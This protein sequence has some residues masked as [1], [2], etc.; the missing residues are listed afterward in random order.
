MKHNFNYWAL[1]EVQT[2]PLSKRWLLFVCY[3]CWDSISTYRRK[4]FTYAISPTVG[5]GSPSKQT[6]NAFSPWAAILKGTR[7]KLLTGH[8]DLQSV[9]SLWWSFDPWRFLIWEKTRTST[10]NMVFMRIGLNGHLWCVSFTA[11]LD[12]RKFVP[13]YI[14][15]CVTTQQRVLVFCCACRWQLENCQRFRWWQNTAKDTRTL[16]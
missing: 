2:P 14:I 7:V 13:K 3:F 6:Q 5:A 15:S 8:C 1:Q 4:K 9:L 16:E 10:R 11:A 12:I